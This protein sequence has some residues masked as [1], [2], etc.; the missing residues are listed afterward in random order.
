MVDLAEA[1]A[2]ILILRDV[3]VVLDA[4]APDLPGTGRRSGM[5]STSR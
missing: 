1:G 2:A 3:A 5:G 4:E